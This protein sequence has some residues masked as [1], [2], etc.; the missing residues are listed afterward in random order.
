[1]MK[2]SFTEK[3]FDELEV[4][5]L[6][7]ILKLR[8]EVFVVEQNCPY[9]DEDD[10]DQLAIHIMGWDGN[11]LAAYARI[12]PAGVYFRNASISRVIIRL[13]YRGTGSGHKLM[14]A[15]I[16]A[17]NDRFSEYGIEISAQAHLK[18]F[19]EHHLFR[20]VS[21]PYLEDGIPHIRMIRNSK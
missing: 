17:L 13:E 16:L 11:T 5:E 1:M 18:S 3:S 21:E 6:Y 2:I 14:A 4:Y 19:Y 9:Q 20:Q 7:E 12:F 8:T 15:S 10:K